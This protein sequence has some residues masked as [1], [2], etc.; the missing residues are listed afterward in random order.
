MAIL[1]P[2]IDP[3]ELSNFVTEEVSQY[4]QDLEQTL[5]GYLPFENINGIDY[6]YQGT[7]TNTYGVL[8]YRAIDAEQ[9]PLGRSTIINL[10]KGEMPFLGGKTMLSERDQL[11]K[12]R[13]DGSDSDFIDFVF[14]DAAFHARAFVDRMEL[15][16]GEA[17]ATD[18]VAIDENGADFEAL[19]FGRP[20]GNTIIAALAW[21]DP[22]ADIL[23]D[24]T[25]W[26]RDY[27]TN[28]A[29]GGSSPG[30]IVMP[31]EVWFN[32]MRNNAIR[33]IVNGAVVASATNAQVSD[34]QLRTVL[35]TYRIPPIVTFDRQATWHDEDLQNP[36][37][38]RVLPDDCLFFMPSD[39]IGK[40]F[41]GQP[42][43]TA[44]NVGIPSSVETPGLVVATWS[45]PHTNQLY[46][47]SDAAALT[48]LGRSAQIYKAQ[49]L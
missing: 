25:T 2:L 32:M 22:N 29:N 11:T 26:L 36:T 14:T 44:Q 12:I 23:G 4:E 38:R 16:R 21:S 8:K 48:I 35:G 9:V 31:E 7:P 34:E 3:V 10:F 42:I 13:M 45:E 6:L 27:R 43:I 28:P 33:E 24:L 47:K 41:M 37:V 46:T 40:V 49:V 19:A 15:Q 39:E 17:I 20:A 1:H 18:Q 30:A 5:A